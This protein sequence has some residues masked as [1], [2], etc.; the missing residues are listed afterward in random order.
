MIYGYARVSTKEQETKGYGLKDQE[1]DLIS[2]GCIK[3]YKDGFTGIKTDR[4]QFKKLLSVLNA[5]DTLVVTKLDRFARSVI[6]VQ[7]DFCKNR[8]LSL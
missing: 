2:E 7:A 5:S 1:K 8:T 6:G 4:P 3:I